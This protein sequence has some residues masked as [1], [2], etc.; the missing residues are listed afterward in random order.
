MVA[1][2][3]KDN[4][5]DIDARMLAQGRESSSLYSLFCALRISSNP[6]PGLSTPRCSDRKILNLV[7]A[8]GDLEDVV[9]VAHEVHV[10]VVLDELRQVV[11]VAPVLFWQDHAG[12]AH[13]FCLGVHSENKIV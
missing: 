7:P 3:V 1:P 13:A 10:D 11:E 12:H 8:E 4:V 5:Q 2:L 9:V 6:Y